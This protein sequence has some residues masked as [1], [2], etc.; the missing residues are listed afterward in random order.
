[1]SIRRHVV[2]LKMIREVRHP[3]QLSADGLS[4][5]I[6]VR[7]RVVTAAIFGL[8]GVIVGGGVNAVVSV[9]LEGRRAATS[10]RASARL[11]AEGI[12]SNGRTLYACMQTGWA[13]DAQP[14]TPLRYL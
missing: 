13:A 9:V 12:Q 14:S 4:P 10:R 1:M 2:S 8:L 3:R 6:P 11:V 5:P 7:S